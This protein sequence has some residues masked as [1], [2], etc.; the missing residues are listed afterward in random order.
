MIS[1]VARGDFASL[2]LHRLGES[3]TVAWL[4]KK[5]GRLLLEQ[6]LRNLYPGGVGVCIDT[7]KLVAYINPIGGVRELSQPWPEYPIH[8]MVNNPS[9][10]E[11]PCREFLDPE[12]GGAWA[13]RGTGEHHPFCMYREGSLERYAH[14]VRLG[15]AAKRPDAWFNSLKGLDRVQ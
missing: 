3:H 12:V 2:P 10:S 6:T 5:G 14:F 11:C 15:H 13:E 8:V 7:C 9:P 1:N 4:M